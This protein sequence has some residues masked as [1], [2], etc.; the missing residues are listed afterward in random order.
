MTRTAGDI[1]TRSVVTVAP[2]L[3]VAELAK[4]LAD[5]GI[6]GVPVVDGTGRLVGIA[7]EA[8]ILRKRPGQ[9]TVQSI[10]TTQ[11][12]AVS[13][14]EPIA[15]VACLLWMK[16]INRVPVVRAGRVVGIVSRGDIISALATS[17]GRNAGKAEPIAG[18]SQGDIA[19][20]AGLPRPK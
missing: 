8:D 6:S 16:R 3:S 13:E 19:A 15:E 4:L 10:M 14:H 17:V 11:V 7:T 2:H 18:S 1:M 12:I 5:N 20:G 9:D